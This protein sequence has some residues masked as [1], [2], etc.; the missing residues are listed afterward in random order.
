MWRTLHPKT[1]VVPSLPAPM[2]WPFLWCFAA[3]IV[4]Y[5]ALLLVRVRLEK[6]RAALEAAYLAV[7]E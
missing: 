7:E 1:S 4:F 3:F 5:V 2:L 6:N